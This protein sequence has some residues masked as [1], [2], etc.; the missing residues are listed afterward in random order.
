MTVHVLQS[1]S[2]DPVTTPP[3]CGTILDPASARLLLQLK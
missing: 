2:P 1:A 3:G